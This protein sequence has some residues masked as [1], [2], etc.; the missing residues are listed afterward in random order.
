M[1]TTTSRFCNAVA[2]EPGPFPARCSL[3]PHETGEHD[4]T[5]S[6]EARRYTDEQQQQLSGA[7]AAAILATRRRS[8]RPTSAGDQLPPR[9]GVVRRVKARRN[10]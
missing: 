2:D 9:K 10:A 4:W 8:P 6:A 7:T 1:T 3:P 5:P